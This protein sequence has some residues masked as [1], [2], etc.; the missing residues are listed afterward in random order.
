MDYFN[1]KIILGMMRLN[2]LSVQDLETIIAGCLKMGIHYFDLSDVYGRTTA[3]EKFGGVMKLH[4]DWRKEMF[5]QTKCGI[6][7]KQDPQTGKDLGTY[8]DLSKDHILSSCEDSLRRMNLD[9]L[10]CYLLHRVDIFMDA[11]EIDSAFRALKTQGKVRQFGVSNMD[12]QQIE[13]LRSGLSEPLVLDQLQLGLGQAS[14]VSQTFNVNA[15]D[16]VPN[17]QDGI[18]FYLKRQ[19]MKLQCWSPLIYG[20]F[21]GSIFIH[22]KMAFTNEVLEKLAK[23][24]GVSKAAIAI[25][26]DC[27]LGENVQVL[28]GS[29][30]LEHLKEAYAGGSLTLSREDWYELYR[31]TGNQLP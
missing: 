7:K 19:G 16:Q 29:M 25:A 22:P 13:Y 18:F 8:M 14:L 2:P 20:L 26:W 9:Y 1:S 17:L 15:P 23:K 10:D 24:Y 21:Q 11:K 12:V 28:V 27:S 30:N 3:E 31:S 6:V 4:P 5:I